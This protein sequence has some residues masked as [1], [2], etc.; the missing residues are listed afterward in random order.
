MGASFRARTPEAIVQEMA[1][2]Q[3][4]YGIRVFDIEDD[5]F[6]FDQERAK[7]LMNLI[8]EIFGEEKIEIS[9]MNGVSFASLD[10]ALLML[11]KR[12]G[13]RTLNLSYVSTDPTTK[14]RMGRP[15]AMTAFNEIVVE[16]ERV[17]L[18]VIAY[19]ILGMPGQTIEEMVDTLI[20]LMGKRVLIGPSVYYPTPGTPLFKRCKRDGLLPSHE[21]QWRSSAFPIETKEFSRIDQLTLFRLSRVI[22]FIKGKM[23]GKELKEGLTW[24]GLCR[25]LEKKVKVETEDKV[26]KD[27]ISWIDLLLLLENERSFFGLR[28][29]SGGRISISKVE[30]SRKVLDCFF[31]KAW[32][33][34]ILKSRSSVV[35]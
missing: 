27:D 3:E 6:T 30:S 12:A 23:D 32:Q 11:M 22:N 1:E 25:V 4:K 14:E 20:H 29:A 24:K 7:R 2:C 10:G 16:A 35:S 8:I 19:A 9:A 26:K 21:C 18:S 15:K 5:N 31:E 13:F 28:R 34:L 17:G 33:R